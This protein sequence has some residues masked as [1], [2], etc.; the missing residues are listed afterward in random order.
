MIEVI[1]VKEERIAL[2]Q[3][4]YKRNGNGTLCPAMRVRSW[5]VNRWIVAQNGESY[6]PPMT[7]KEADA[8]A[9]KLRKENPCT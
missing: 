9:E 1:P 2:R 3:R 5:W 6:S 4:G 8:L 7:K